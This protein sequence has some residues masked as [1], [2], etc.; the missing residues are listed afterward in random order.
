MGVVAKLRDAGV[1]LRLVDGNVEYVAATPLTDDELARLK[2]NKAAILRELL[3]VAPED[4]R[5]IRAWL[6]SIG[7]DDEQTIIEILGNCGR[8]PE[9]LAY[10]LGRASE[11]VGHDSQPLGLVQCI[12]CCHFQRTDHPH[13]GHCAVGKPEAVAG[14]WDM[15]RR[16]CRRRLPLQQ[17]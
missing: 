5:R 12:N 15:D 2:A 16:A 11:V 13:L 14:L 6:A 17:T 4:E 1:D 10:F 7:E 9:A 8:N 3:G